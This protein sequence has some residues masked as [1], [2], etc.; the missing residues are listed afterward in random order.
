M[1]VVLKRGQKVLSFCQIYFSSNE[2]VP[3]SNRDMFIKQ[4]VNMT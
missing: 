1:F 3:E 2:G 4:K